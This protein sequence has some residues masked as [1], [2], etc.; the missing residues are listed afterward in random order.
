VIGRI[1]IPDLFYR[2]I[3][4][5]TER[6]RD[7][8]VTDRPEANPDPITG[9]PGSHPVGT[10]VGA[11]GGGAAGAAIG[12]AVSGPAA[13]V[14]AAVGAVIGAVAGGLAGKG[15]AESVNP[16]AEEEYW[17]SNYATRP[18]AD[19]NLSYDEFSPAYRYG[20][21][22]RTRYADRRF[23]DVESDLGRDWNRAKGQSRLSWDR[24]KLATRDAW[25]RVENKFKSGSGRDAR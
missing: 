8:K 2:S 14:G 22:S 7:S 5:A 4:M 25:D 17:R 1:E 16:T 3:T 12:A 11:A 24:A 18:Y 21:E 15:V 19:S 20:W 10:G 13:P 23:E 6:N 9:A